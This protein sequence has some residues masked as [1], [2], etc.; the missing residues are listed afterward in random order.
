MA[1]PLH[2]GVIK[3]NV[4]AALTVGQ[5]VCHVSSICQAH[6]TPDLRA[7]KRGSARP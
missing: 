7:A 1:Y 6:L 5:M 3:A 4:Q 2:L